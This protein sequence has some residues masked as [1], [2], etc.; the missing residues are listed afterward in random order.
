[1]PSRNPHFAKF[2][3]GYLFP[4]ITKRKNAFLQE[5]PSAHLIYLGIGDTTSPLPE[6]IVKAV[7]EEAHALGTTQGYT[8]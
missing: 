5:E 6:V 1:M 7:K 3:S 4:E 2:H 8:G